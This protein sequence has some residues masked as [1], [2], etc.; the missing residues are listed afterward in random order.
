MLKSSGDKSVDQWSIYKQK[1]PTQEVKDFKR[2]FS[3]HVGQDRTLTI[4]LDI[5]RIISLILD[6]TP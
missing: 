5:L 6:D 3:I 1:I 4:L 2:C